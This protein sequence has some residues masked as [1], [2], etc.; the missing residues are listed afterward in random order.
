MARNGVPSQNDAGVSNGIMNFANLVL[1]LSA[2]FSDKK[3]K[4]R[5]IFEI[6]G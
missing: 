6:C 1:D 4:I 5:M 2:G 3:E